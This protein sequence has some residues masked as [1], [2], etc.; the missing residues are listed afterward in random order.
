LMD[1]LVAKHI[2]TWLP[3]DMSMWHLHWVNKT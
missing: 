2:F 1:D 3:M